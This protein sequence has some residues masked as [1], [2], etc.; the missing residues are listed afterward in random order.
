MTESA[1]SQEIAA[2]SAGAW[3]RQ[4]REQAGQSIDAV[5]ATLKVPVRTLAALE[6]DDHA[7]LRDAVFIRALAQSVCRVLHRDPAPVL[8]LLPAASLRN[9]QP[10]PV[11]DEIHSADMRFK[12]RAQWPALVFRPLTL[13]L[14]LIMLGALAVAFVPDTWLVW[15]W[16]S[17][18]DGAPAAAPGSVALPLP[19]EVPAGTSTAVPVEAA[20]SPVADTAPSA[21]APAPPPPAVRP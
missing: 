11:Q 7:G 18:P 9:P 21:P 2:A 1:P 15:P 13:V 12:R 3:L 6:A 8:Q 14:V 16:G 4:A 19:L 17:A 20:P 5:A 10:L